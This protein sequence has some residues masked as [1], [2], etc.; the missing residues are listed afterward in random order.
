MSRNALVTGANGFI[1]SH[2]VEGLLARNYRVLGLV[3]KTS[4]LEWLKDLP[5]ELHY[6]EVTDR[7]SLYPV[8]KDVDFIFHT[9]GATKARN[10]AEYENI[11]YQ[12]TKNLLEV[13]LETNPNLKRL[14]YFSSLAAAGPSNNSHPKNEAGE[15]LPVSLY[16]EAKLKTEKLVVEFGKKL[17]TV[18]LRLPTVYGPR[19][20]D[21]L[22][23]FQILKKGFR[24]VFGDM[25]S[26][27]FIK[28]TVAAAMLCIEKDIK[29]G[30][31]YCVSD[32]NCYSL[33]EMADIAEKLIGVNTFRFR[34]PKP[35]LSLYAG[36]IGKFSKSQTIINQD[37]IKELTQKCWTCN[38]NK[39]RNEL[40]FNP[41]FN[42]VEGLKL[43]IGWYKERRWL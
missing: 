32:G 23:Y 4:N 35:V 24:P 26:V 29:S 2:L 13:C 36:L 9:A 10:K 15:C 8:V 28:D 11:N 16:G 25:F 31:I 21:G 43:T 14:V 38:I 42:L 27:L 18:I 33:D 1:G 30:E 20:R 5:V 39:I 22:A 37:K 12:G 3:R 40:G 6:G 41:Q 7:Q 17:P 34:V 19:D